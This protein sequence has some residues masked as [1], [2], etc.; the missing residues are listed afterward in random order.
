MARTGFP[1]L[2]RHHGVAFEDVVVMTTSSGRFVTFVYPHV[3][4]A[5]VHI[6]RRYVSF[7]KYITMFLV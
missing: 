1:A 2:L 7:C 3:C 6:M 5:D 4:C